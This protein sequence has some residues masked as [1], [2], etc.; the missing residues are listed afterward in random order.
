MATPE[1]P[2]LPEKLMDF[3][4][5]GPLEELAPLAP[6]DPPRSFC[7]SFTTMIYCWLA[8]FKS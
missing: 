6:L 5:P 3:V 2:P 4:V 8:D 7:F 1:L